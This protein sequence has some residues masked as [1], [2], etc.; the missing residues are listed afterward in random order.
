MGKVARGT[1]HDEQLPEIRPAVLAVGEMA[2]EVAPEG[3]AD[4]AFQ[5]V[6]RQVHHIT[7]DDL[8]EVM[9]SAVIHRGIPPRPGELESLPDAGEPAHWSD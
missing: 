3:A 8:A 9:S 7:T 4:D 1:D 6:G 5:V 2:V